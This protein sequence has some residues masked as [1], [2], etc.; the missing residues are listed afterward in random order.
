MISFDE[1]VRVTYLASMLERVMIGCFFELQEMAPLPMKNVNPE[2]EWWWSCDAQSTSKYLVMVEWGPPRTNFQPFVPDREQKT[3]V[4]A[5]RCIV[6]GTSRCWDRVE[7]ANV[8]S[9]HVMTVAYMRHPIISWYL[10]FLA[11]VSRVA[12]RWDDPGLR[13]S[14]TS[15]GV[16][17][18]WAFSRPK[19]LRICLM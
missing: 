11:G 3:G 13:S 7:T 9:G 17:A 16:T 12:K 4:T 14:P 6:W 5:W 1:W 2:I 15:I 19:W 8:M 18:L 10:V